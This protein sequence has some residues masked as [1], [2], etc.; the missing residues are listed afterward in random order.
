MKLTVLQWNVWYREDVHHVVDFLRDHPADIYCLQE[1]LV[2]GQGQPENHAPSFL[3]AQLGLHMHIQEVPVVEDGHSF[4]LAS[5][6]FTK[7]PIISTNYTWINQP[8]GT[9]SYEDAYRAYVEAK[10]A[11]A[12]GSELVVGTAQSSYTHQY[13]ETPRK[14]AEI[15]ALIAQLG[16]HQNRFIFAAD[17]NATPASSSVEAVSRVLTDVGPNLIEPTWT[18]KPF[19]ERGFEA[20]R[21]GWRLDYIFTTADIATQSAEI[22]PTVYSD[23]LPIFATLEV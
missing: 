6:I 10:L 21:L 2:A 20:S 7:L 18:T 12:D 13:E 22:L 8:Q 16:R 11:L 19:S 15:Q 23:H 1:M 3:A 9:G 14:Q 4:G 5:G 17:L